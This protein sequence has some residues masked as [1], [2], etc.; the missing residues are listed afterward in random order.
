MTDPFPNQPGD[1]PNQPGQPGRWGAPDGGGWQQP[2][3][4]ELT[5]AAGQWEP[6]DYPAGG[7][8]P[9]PAA[10]YYPQLPV[11]PAPARRGRLPWLL[12]ALAAV[13]LL[14]VGGGGVAAYRLLNGGGT[15]PDEVIPASAIG[16]A[17]LDLNPAAGQKLAA[18]RFLKRIPKYGNGFS[19]A[20][21]WRKPL[22]DALSGSDALPPTV[23]F[24]RDIKPWLGKRLAVALLPGGAN[25]EPDTLIAVQSTNDGQ[26]RAGIARFGGGYGISF[27]KGYAILGRSQQLTDQA[28]SQA[29]AASLSNAP[30]YHADLAKL[31]SLGISS[32]WLDLAALAELAGHGP[33]AATLPT[34]GALAYTVRFTGNTAELVAKVYGQ[35]SSQPQ[36]VTGLPGIG[37]L[38]ASTAIALQTTWLGSR[39]DQSW[40]RLNQALAGLDDPDGAGPASALEQ[41]QQQFG[42]NLPGDLDS[43]LGSG[44]LVAVDSSGLGGGDVPKLAMRTKT[45]S[46]AALAVLDKLS[47]NLGDRFPLKYQATANGVIVAT[48]Q[49]YLASLAAPAGDRLGKLASFSA[50]LP[51]L[52]G[53]ALSAYV[54]LTAITAELAKQGSSAADLAQLSDFSAIGLTEGVE[55]GV[56]TVHIRLVAR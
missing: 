42:L 38:P 24:D 31:G 39:L 6:T 46:A 15:Q 48:D 12:G 45:D 18:A 17:K 54:N 35:P 56:S 25:T 5:P 27:L 3:I 14:L 50:A 34:T 52:S 26:A 44:M 47:A 1:P 33:A 16:F 30:D 2:P 11:P 29:R 20:G 4:V 22:F 51:E 21:D 43:V 8:Y 9:P 40:Q 37:E 23:S 36:P 28:V 41:F 53:S 32:G 10:G 7:Y 13:L 19:T 49:S 55:Q